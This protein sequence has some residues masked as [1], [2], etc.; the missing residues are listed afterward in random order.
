M[1]A[2]HRHLLRIIKVIL[3]V[4][5]FT[6]IAFTSFAWWQGEKLDL[7]IWTGIG[8]GVS[9]VSMCLVDYISNTQTYRTCEECGSSDLT[10]PVSCHIGKIPGKCQDCGNTFW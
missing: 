9:L 6:T 7:G 10:F 2:K 4:S 3:A 5:C 8:M 1:K